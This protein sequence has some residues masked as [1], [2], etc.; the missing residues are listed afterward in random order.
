MPAQLGG[1]SIVKPIPRGV[2]LQTR[3]LLGT[4]LD[5][6][7][8][9]THTTQ[10]LSGS[11]R[12]FELF[13]RE[14]D[15]LHV[16]YITGRHL[17]LALEG[18]DQF[19]LPWPDTLVCDV[20]TSIYHLRDGRWKLDDRYRAAMRS[21]LGGSSARKVEEVLRPVAALRPQ[22]EERQKEFKRSYTVSGD[23]S[24]VVEEV[25][26]RTREAGLLVSLVASDDSTTGEGLLD[27][28]P[29]G[30][31]KHT[32]LR[33]LS[34]Q[35]ALDRDHVAFAGDSGNDLEALLSG[36]WG[37][38]VGNAPQDLREELRR[39][40]HEAGLGARIYFA[41]AECAAGVLEGLRYFGWVSTPPRRGPDV[42]GAL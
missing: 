23:R 6:T 22:V 27:V 10:D 28:L 25:R 20:G 7:I 24:A 21:A 1:Q 35:L 30:V 40:A 29:R 38:L 8:L 12:E 36:A 11:V 3:K 19:S 14:Q 15:E 41:R 2:K 34:A 42:T 18:L 5:G 33:F 16:A 9:P 31:A 17:E 4:D 37:I 13:L 26:R 39:R 32:A